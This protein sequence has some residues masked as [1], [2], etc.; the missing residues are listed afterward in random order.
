MIQITQPITLDVWRKTIFD[1]IIAKQYDVNSRFLIVTINENGEKYTVPA[2]A[3]VSINCLRPD[4]QSNSYAGEANDDG[5]VTVPIPA[6]ALQLDGNV[7]CD[8]TVADDVSVLKTLKFTVE[9]QEAVADDTEISEDEYTLWQEIL[10]NAREAEESAENAATAATTAQ[11]AAETAVNRV[12]T[13]ETNVTVAEEARI[14]AE[15]QRA[16]AEQSR[17]TAES[18]RVSAEQER[19]TAENARVNAEQQRAS[20]E[21][22]RASAESSR[23]SAESGRTTAEQGRVTA[24]AARVAAEQQRAT[25]YA[26]LQEELGDSIENINNAAQS[27]EIVQEIAAQMGIAFYYDEQGYVCADEITVDSTTN[28]NN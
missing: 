19:V 9:V 10:M 8:I 22:A 20:A 25:D 21:T 6:W 11:Q 12:N 7:E 17:A 26:A 4:G 28:N 2:T 23:A 27:A 3:S 1:A 5:T 13:L 16:Q 18:G 15:Q 14:A 24:E